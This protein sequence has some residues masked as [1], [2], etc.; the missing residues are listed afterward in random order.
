MVWIV[1]HKGEIKKFYTL[2]D[3][4][5]Y[6]GIFRWKLAGC[7]NREVFSINGY[8]VRR[9]KSETLKGRWAKLQAALIGV[10]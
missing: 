2:T 1:E 5:D 4:A 7:E 3:V 10:N 6:I 9:E 8:L